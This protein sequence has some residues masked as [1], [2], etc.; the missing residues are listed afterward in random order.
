MSYENSHSI[1]GDDK[2][3]QNRLCTSYRTKILIFINFFCKCDV[4]L[5]QVHTKNCFL[6]KIGLLDF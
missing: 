5:L 2:G 6:E 1:D 4:N 3:T